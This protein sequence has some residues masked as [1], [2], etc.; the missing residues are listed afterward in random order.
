[1]TEEKEKEF[2]KRVDDI[3]VFRTNLADREDVPLNY[4]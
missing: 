2:E 3:R 4:P 1:M